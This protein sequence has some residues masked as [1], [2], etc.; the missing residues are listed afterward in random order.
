MGSEMCIRDRH[1]KTIRKFYGSKGRNK[2]S[3][4]GDNDYGDNVPAGL[5][6]LSIKAGNTIKS[7]KILLL[8]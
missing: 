7:A 6:F 5:Y 1:I 2:I 3:W 4:N 8:E